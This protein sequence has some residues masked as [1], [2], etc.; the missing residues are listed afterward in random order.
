MKKPL[1][2]RPVIFVSLILMLASLVLSGCWLR[3]PVK[4]VVATDTPSP[5]SSAKLALKASILGSWELIKQDGEEIPAG[6]ARVVYEFAD[7]QNLT[8]Y[9][10]AVPYPC[11]YKWINDY[12]IEV[13]QLKN[14]MTDKEYKFVEMVEIIANDLYLEI[15]DED[16]ET[17][18]GIFHRL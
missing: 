11:T 15:T 7:E 10:G 12:T 17:S 8:V 3:P 4:D 2:G 16:N 5:D 9:F 13:I 1:S 6:S 14:A 18:Q